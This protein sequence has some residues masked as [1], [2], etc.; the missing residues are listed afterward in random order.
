[1]TPEDYLFNQRDS[2]LCAQPQA[3]SLEVLPNTNQGPEDV[4]DEVGLVGVPKHQFT[5]RFKYYDTFQ[6][7]MM[8]HDTELIFL[9]V[10]PS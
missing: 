2:N 9:Q 10:D 1:M 6:A 4:T 8:R 3:K 7:E 5:E